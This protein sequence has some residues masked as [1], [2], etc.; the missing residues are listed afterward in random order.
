MNL[1][2]SR[3][4]RIMALGDEKHPSLLIEFED[5]RTAQMYQRIDEEV[6]FRMT[7]VDEENQ[8]EIFP[9]C[10]DYFSLFIDAMIQFFDTGEIPVP[11]EQTIDVIAVRAA[12]RKAFATPYEW[13]TI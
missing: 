11:K 7:V 5:G 10:S 8:A 9:I 6:S 13:I 1:M 2:N 4:T 3:V 12:G